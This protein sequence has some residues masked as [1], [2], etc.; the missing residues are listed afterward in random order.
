MN[1]FMGVGWEKKRSYLIAALAVLIAAIVITAIFYP[2]PAKPS[3]AETAIIHEEDLATP[4]W[5]SVGSLSN[6]YNDE[7]M[8][9]LTSAAGY[10]LALWNQSSDPTKYSRLDIDCCL[11]I[12]K[13]AKDAEAE[14]NRYYNASWNDQRIGFADAAVLNIRPIDGGKDFFSA[15]SFIRANALSTI[16]I[17]VDLSNIPFTYEEFMNWTMMAATTQEYKLIWT[18]VVVG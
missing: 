7:G 16:R 13:S 9:N 18:G 6:N 17:D 12:F 10:E 15:I 8:K 14:F 1:P 3:Q 4:G 11:F 2:R 5:Q